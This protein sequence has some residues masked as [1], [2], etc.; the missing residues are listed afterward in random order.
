MRVLCRPGGS[1]SHS[2][3]RRPSAA[4]ATSCSSR[5]G[6]GCPQGLQA[7]IPQA[8]S[9][10]SATGSKG[11]STLGCSVAR[12][13]WRR[14]LEEQRRQLFFVIGGGLM[15]SGSRPLPPTFVANFVEI[16][17][18]NRDDKGWRQ[19]LRRGRPAQVWSWAVQTMHDRLG[20]GRIRGQGPRV[21]GFYSIGLQ[22]LTHERV[23]LARE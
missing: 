1:A 12:A 17:I 3:C 6:T 10:A 22:E 5:P 15:N 16:P 13:G 11:N 8:L 9:R 2:P 23:G 21:A 20:Q 19:R 4:G 18:P 14:Y 7:R